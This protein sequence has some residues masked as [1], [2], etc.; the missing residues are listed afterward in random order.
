MWE[1]RNKGTNTWNKEKTN[2]Q[3][4]DLSVTRLNLFIYFKFLLL[5]LN[6]PN[7]PMNN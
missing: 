4:L 7:T 5:N 6:V 2:N 1:M 3:E